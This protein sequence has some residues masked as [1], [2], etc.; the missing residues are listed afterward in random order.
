MKQEI[1]GAL[2]RGKKKVEK[3]SPELCLA[4]GVL[5]GVGCVIFA[6][7]ATLH[8]EEV[9]D[10]H[11]ERMRLAKEAAKVARPEDHYDLNREK[12]VVTAHTFADF[13]KLYWRSVALG[14]LSLALILKGHRILSN[15][16]AGAVAFGNAVSEAFS[17]YR[18]R[19]IA[20]QGMEKD[21][22]YRFGK[23]EISK[24]AVVSVN[25][26]GTSETKEETVE[27]LDV[28][29][30]DYAKI[31][32]HTN[33]NWDPNPTYNLKWLK[34]ME[35]EATM[36][37]KGRS[38]YDRKGRLIKP[39]SLALN[40]VYHMLGFD[41][42]PIGAVTGWI[43]DGNGDPQVDFG[44]YDM[45][46]EDVVRFVNGKDANVILDFNVDGVIIDKL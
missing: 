6:C 7:K 21:R 34:S 46:R 42:T 23:P 2:Y 8:A 4:G 43:D 3:C 20:D 9:L 44:L 5:A 14:G 15:R 33:R 22:E 10:R 45:S 18:E 36:L 37:L 40:E 11:Q 13:A 26:D 17:Q 27:S 28:S 41:P 24:Q 1:M 39:G 29:P 12:F 31:F 32:D 19:V 38:R 25:E 16:Y 30:S 35:R